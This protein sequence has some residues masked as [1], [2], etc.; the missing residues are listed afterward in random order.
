VL[1]HFRQAHRS[2]LC[3]VH[4]QSDTPNHSQMPK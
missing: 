2:G 4:Q 1:R 3:Q